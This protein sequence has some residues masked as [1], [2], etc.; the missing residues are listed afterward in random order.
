MAVTSGNVQTVWVAITVRR[1]RFTSTRAYAMRAA[2]PMMSHGSTS[3]A[4]TKPPIAPRP[5]KRNRVRPNAAKVPSTRQS[6]RDH[7]G[8][9]ERVGDR[10]PQR[11]VG[12]RIGV[13]VQGE[14]LE[15]ERQHARVVEREQHQDQKRAEQREHHDGEEQ[16]PSP[17]VGPAASPRPGGALDVGDRE[18]APFLDRLD[19]YDALT[20]VQA[21]IH[22]SRLSG[23]LAGIALSRVNSESS[24]ASSTTFGGTAS[25]MPWF[26]VR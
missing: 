9:H 19:H 14:A 3:G 20:S 7:Q 10:L 18:A 22:A 15:R 8:H 11:G 6:G 1:L 5:V 13:P 21:A 4:P 24:A 17:R 12:Q 16:P 2:I 25:M 23:G 26:D